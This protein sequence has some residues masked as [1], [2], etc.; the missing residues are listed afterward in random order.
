MGRQATDRSRH[1]CTTPDEIEQDYDS[2][3]GLEPEAMSAVVAD[4]GANPDRLSLV[5]KARGLEHH[6]GGTVFQ[7]GDDAD[8]LP[9]HLARSQTD[10]DACLRAALP[11]KCFVPN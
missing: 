4:G 10:S 3:V 11:T 8:Q 1:G 5:R 2:V 6:K 9:G 7:V